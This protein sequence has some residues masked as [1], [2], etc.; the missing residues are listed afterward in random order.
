M[1]QNEIFEKLF[2]GGNISTHYL[3]KFTHPSAGVIRLVN[4]NA[5][6]QYN[7]ETYAI[8]SFSY[9]EPD[10]YGDGGNL[11]ISGIDNDLIE[12]FEDADHRYTMEVVGIIASNG[13]VQ[14][15]KGIRHFYGS[16]SYDE[17]QEIQFQLGKDDRLDMKFCPYMYDTLSN[18]GNA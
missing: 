10:I 1:T 18:K 15:L 11:S 9:T 16:I 13:E 4:N 2:N 12:F 3:I 8:S 17:T 14:R 7:N 6:V 5:S